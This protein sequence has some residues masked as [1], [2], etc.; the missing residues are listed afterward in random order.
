MNTV[1]F[2][3]SWITAVALATC[4]A[5]TNVMAKSSQ[6]LEYAQAHQR[7]TQALIWGLPAVSMK[8]FHE[9]MKAVGADDYGDIVYFSKP[10]VSRHGFLTANNNVP[11]VAFSEYQS[12]AGGSGCA[13]RHRKVPVL[14][15]CPGHVA[16][17]G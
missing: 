2:N 17:A 11:Y 10:M 15:Q 1:K 13:C 7:G 14:R 4:L 6:S 16:D 5:S 9:G 12:G 3:T 8:F